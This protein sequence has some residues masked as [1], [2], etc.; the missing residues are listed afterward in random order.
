MG[1][2]QDTAT[3]CGHMVP[4]PSN[5]SQLIGC[6]GTKSTVYEYDDNGQCVSQQSYPCGSC[7]RG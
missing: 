7:G 2:R 3:P 4:D 5:P 6:T 1:H